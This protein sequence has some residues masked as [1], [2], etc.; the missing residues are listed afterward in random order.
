[1]N[2]LGSDIARLDAERAVKYPRVSDSTAF[3]HGRLLGAT[4]DASQSVEMVTERNASCAA[5]GS[6]F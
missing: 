1:M 3:M 4:P 6:R 2:Q 5:N